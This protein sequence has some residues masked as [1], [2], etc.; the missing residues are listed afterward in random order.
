MA[1]PRLAVRR[2]RPVGVEVPMK[3]PLGTSAG[4]LRPPSS[5]VPRSFPIVREREVSGT[6]K[7]VKRYRMA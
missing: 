2:I 1:A 3:L 7:A 5:T 6:K 4:T